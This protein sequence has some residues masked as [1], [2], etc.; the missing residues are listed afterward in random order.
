MLSDTL[1]TFASVTVTENNIKSTQL[2]LCGNSCTLVKAGKYGPSHILSGC[3][4]LALR[5]EKDLLL[6]FC[7]SDSASLF[8]IWRRACSEDPLVWTASRC[9]FLCFSC[10]SDI[11]LL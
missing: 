10:I 2:I 5:L 8:V 3:V 11:L 7:S 1:S 9:L 4:R 6:T